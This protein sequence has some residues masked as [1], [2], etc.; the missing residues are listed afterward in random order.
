MTTPTIE[1]DV[2][3]NRRG[4]GGRKVLAAGAAPSSPPPGR[5]PRVAKL[6][7]LAIRFDGLVRDGAVGSYAELARLGQVTR[8]RVTQIMNLLHLAPDIQEAI[9]FL[10][11]VERGRDRIVLRDLQPVA[12]VLDWREQRERWNALSRHAA[13]S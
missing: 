4:R 11:R 12:A 3:F 13:R 5:V 1:C 8:A 2:H 6:M 9:L 10:P 7:A